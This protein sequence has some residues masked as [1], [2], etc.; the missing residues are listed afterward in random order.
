[1]GARLPAGER[2]AAILRSAVAMFATRGFSGVTTRELADSAGVSEAMLYKHFPHK[3]ALYRAILERHLEDVEEA[4]PIDGLATSDLP[5]ER[6]FTE[7]GGTILRRMEEDPTLLRLM[8]FSALE[9]HPLARDFE[10]A[11]ARR[12]R[13][14]IA[15]Y[16]RRMGKQ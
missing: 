14:A 11:R 1:M 7:I 4:V 3:E 15:S 16:L 2:K 5:P 12:L 8:F 10:R 13:D 9:G 6:F